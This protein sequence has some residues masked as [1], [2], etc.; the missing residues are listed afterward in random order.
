MASDEELFARVRGGDL[1][2]FDALYARYES[3]LFGFL[4]RQL[5][6]REEAEDVFHE[7]FMNALRSRDIDF[8]RASFRTW[9]Y[10]IAR[11]LVLNRAR[12]KERQGRAF[13]RLP[14]ADP[15]ASAEHALEQ[16]ERKRA[17]DTAVARLP[18]ALADVYHLRSA[19]LSYEEMAAVLEIPM[20]TLKSRMNAMVERL[21]GE[22]SSWIAH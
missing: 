15:E 4:V 13:A 2:A 6:S 20:G 10:R 9:L 7:T 21:R 8:D 1:A 5:K 12:A 19:G 14:E 11:N 22:L 18:E 16:A 17:L 3:R